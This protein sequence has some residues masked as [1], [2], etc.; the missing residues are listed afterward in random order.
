MTEERKMALALRA[1][2]RILAN[3][4][5]SDFVVQYGASALAG[6][7]EYSSDMAA[8]IVD[9]VIEGVIESNDA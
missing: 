3:L 9:E 5:T 1:V 4:A 7:R 2:N 8:D 6:L